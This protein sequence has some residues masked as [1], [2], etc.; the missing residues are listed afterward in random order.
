MCGGCVWLGP[1]VTIGCPFMYDLILILGN[2]NVFSIETL[3]VSL[4]KN[5]YEYLIW[6]ALFACIKYVIQFSFH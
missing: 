6:F 2:E 3:Y 1:R 5:S 4:L